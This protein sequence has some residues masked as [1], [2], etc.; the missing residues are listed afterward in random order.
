MS[1]FTTKKIC[2]RGAQINTPNPFDSHSRSIDP[3]LFDDEGFELKTQF[4]NVKAKTIIN[5]VESPDVPLGY[6]LNPYQGCEHG[7][8]Y[9]Y[10][11]NSHTYWGYSAGLD[12][13][14]KILVKQNAVELLRKKLK[15]KN[16]TA[17]PIML[18]GNTDCY[19]P[20]ERKFKITRELLKCFL[21][22]GHPV[23]LITK[24]ALILRDLDIIKKLNEQNLVSV[25]LS[26]N[27]TDDTIRSFLEPRTSTIEKRLH[28]V[29]VLSENNIP[30]TVLAAPI[31]PGLTDHTILPLAKEA[32]AA[33]ANSLNHIIVRLNGDIAQI[34]SDWLY[35]HFP[36][37]ASKILNQIKETHGGQLNDSN[38][39]RRMRGEGVIAE[40]IK[41][42]FDLAKKRYFPNAYDF[43]Y[44]LELYDQLKNPQLKLF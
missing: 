41:Q 19:Q 7:C 44:N 13:E 5:K 3:D 4:I 18:S 22:F 43:K 26:I 40:I 14:S 27:T 17:H 20:C 34:F 25:A 39:G 6:S 8:V 38:W 24:N 37:R 21:E 42:Q 9:C 33:G 29:R 15:S 23:G 32:A 36:D 28:A 31:V 30:V 11:R 12:F 35:K 16:W 2:G 1:E 10:A